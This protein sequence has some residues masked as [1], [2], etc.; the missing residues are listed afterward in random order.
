[1][2][3]KLLRRFGYI[4]ASSAPYEVKITHRRDGETFVVIRIRRHGMRISGWLVPCDPKDRDPFAVHD[5]TPTGPS[6]QQI[7]ARD[8]DDTYTGSA[9][10]LTR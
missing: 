9:R 6:R 3:E 1:M 8:H 5:M 10:P 4:P 7:V 2:I